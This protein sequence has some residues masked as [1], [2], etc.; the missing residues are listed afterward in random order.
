[1][2]WFFRKASL[3]L[4][5]SKF[6]SADF[7]NSLLG[8]LTAILASCFSSGSE[9]KTALTGNFFACL[10][11]AKSRSMLFLLLS[12]L[13]FPKE[14]FINSNYGIIINSKVIDSAQ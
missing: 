4:L 1:M 7:L 2:F 13:F 9:K 12:L 10:P 14:K 3:I 11:S 5:F 6:L 8:T